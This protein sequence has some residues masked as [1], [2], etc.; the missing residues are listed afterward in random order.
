[1][2]GMKIHDGTAKSWN[3]QTVVIHMWKNQIL[4]PSGFGTWIVCCHCFTVLFVMKAESLSHSDSRS[5]TVSVS[6][7]FVSAH[8]WSLCLLLFGRQPSGSSVNHE[9]RSGE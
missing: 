9:D 4:I 3:V 7:L 1:M 6:L 5:V 2:R 8:I